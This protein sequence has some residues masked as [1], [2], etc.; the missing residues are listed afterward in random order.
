MNSRDDRSDD[1]AQLLAEHQT[2]LFG[3]IF[4]M[5]PNMADAEDVY[6]ETVVALWQKF[7]DYEPGTNF[8]GWA[9]VVAKFK[10]QHF[11]RTKSRRRVHFD[12]ELVTQ[13]SET[14]A[15][16]ESPAPG[17]LVNSFTPALVHCISLLP[18]N[19][20]QLIQLCYEEE[21][22]LT[23]V[24]KQFGRSPQSIWNSLSRIRRVLFDCIRQS[25]SAEEQ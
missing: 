2:Q 7:N 9:R 19:D 8:A 14:L 16:S 23:Q 13:L 4:A 22:S 3:Y 18:K 17:S 6:Q 12:E 25:H 20:H 11:F 10:V 1:F 5:I 15:R 24:A 21:Q